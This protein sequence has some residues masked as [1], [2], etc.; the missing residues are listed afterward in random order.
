M[1]YLTLLASTFIQT[2]LQEPLSEAV[3]PTLRLPQLRKVNRTFNVPPTLPIMSNP[4]QSASTQPTDQEPPS[5][6]QGS[7]TANAPYDQGNTP[8][9]ASQSAS[10]N[11][12][13]NAKQ[14]AGTADEAFDGGNQPGESYHLI[15]PTDCAVFEAEDGSGSMLTD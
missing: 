1:S 3:Y 14:G 5:G 12:P 9:A 4:K 8:E 15:F 13:P 7:G 6:V 2:C 10:E 11:E